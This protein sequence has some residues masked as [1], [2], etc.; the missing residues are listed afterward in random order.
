[1]RKEAASAKKEQSAGEEKR[2]AERRRGSSARSTPCARRPSAR[3]SSAR[4]TER[5]A[6]QKRA[7]RARTRRCAQADA[8]AQ[9]QR[10]PTRARA[11]PQ[12]AARAAARRPTGIAASSAKI[13][14]NVILPPDIAGNPEAIFEVVQLPTG[15]IIDAQLQKSSG[16]R[17]YDEAVQRAIL[18]I[19][20]AAA[21][22]TSARPVPAR[23]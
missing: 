5:D 14:G 1:M 10:E 4:K 15:E 16:V 6:Q 13:K 20:A 19:V 2:Q 12:A 7:G 21:S 18:Q 11:P 3:R 17:A 9:A 8:K 23:V 22:P